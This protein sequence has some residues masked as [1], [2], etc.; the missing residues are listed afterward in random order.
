M[1]SK[2]SMQTT[3]SDFGSHSVSLVLTLCQTK[4]NDN[5]ILRIAVKLLFN[6]VFSDNGQNSSSWSKM[7]IIP[8]ICHPEVVTHL[9]T[10]QVHCFLT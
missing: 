6:P 2:L 5:N 8:A 9:S 10:D 1:V 4:L 7:L 3:V